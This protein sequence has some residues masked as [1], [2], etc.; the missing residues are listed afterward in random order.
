MAW[1]S[2]NSLAMPYSAKQRLLRLRRRDRIAPPRL[3]PAGLANA[4]PRFRFHD[5]FPVQFCRCADQSVQ[6]GRARPETRRSQIG[7][8]TRDPSRVLNCPKRIPAQRGVA[9]GQIFRQRLP[10]RRIV[11][12]RYRAAADDAGIAIGGLAARLAP[13]DQNDRHPALS[14]G[15]GCRYA[16]DARAEHHDIHFVFRPSTFQTPSRRYQRRYLLSFKTGLQTTERARKRSVGN[17]TRPS[18]LRTGSNPSRT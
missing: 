13:V 15:I 10:Q 2:S 5:P 14:R 17:G 7:Q 4:M 8:K 9:V 3:E 11:E 12:R 16:D 6:R 1:R 18:V